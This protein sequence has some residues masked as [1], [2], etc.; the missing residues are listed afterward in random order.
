MLSWLVQ[1]SLAKIRRAAR[2]TIG[3]SSNNPPGRTT[4]AIQN[5]AV[6]KE[7]MGG[8]LP[9]RCQAMCDMDHGR[10]ESVAPVNYAK[11]ILQGSLSPSSDG[12]PETSASNAPWAVRESVENWHIFRS[13]PL[14]GPTL[15]QRLRTQADT[16]CCNRLLELA[17]PHRYQIKIR[18]RKYNNN[19]M[20]LRGGSHG[21]QG[22]R[23]G[24]VGRGTGGVANG[25]DGR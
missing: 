9:F 2:I 23:G 17:R 12:A 13:L 18:N 14:P 20:I 21:A 6:R 25:E 4:A 7:L 10:Q 8:I 11:A 24:P 19:A 15:I 16:H 3:A 22:G 1:A 5:K